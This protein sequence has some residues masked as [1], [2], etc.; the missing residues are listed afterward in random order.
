MQAAQPGAS[1]EWLRKIGLYVSDSN[2]TIDLSQLRIKFRVFQADA[3]HAEPAHAEITVYNL[4]DKTIQS[5]LTEFTTVTLQAGYENGNYSVIFQ[6]QIRQFKHGHE[7]PI[8]S[9]LIIYAA[10]GDPAHMF[11]FVNQ[12]LA[13]GWTAND[14]IRAA[15]DAMGP[16]G[17]TM[18]WNGIANSGLLPQNARGVLMT[19]LGA[20]ILDETGHTN[21]FTWRIEQGQVQICPVNGYGPNDV[22]V[23]NSQSGLIGWPEVTQGGITAT[24]LL[25]PTLKVFNRVQ[26]DNAAIN[27]TTA[28]PS[29]RIPGAPT[30]TSYPGINDLN[31]YVSTAADGIYRI[32]VVEH[33]G[34][35]RGA[36][37]FSHLTLLNLDSSA[38]PDNAVVNAPVNQDFSGGPNG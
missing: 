20:G 24:C 14:K 32:L 7:S 25:N 9:Y 31:Y 36:P 21:G 19:G 8:D 15:V 3:W 28:P 30:V 22:V 12:T 2:Q 38:P 4:K 1:D 23:L 18:G 27:Q 10:D 17:V 13:P 29:L 34:D 16:Y 6:G 11:G 26:I 37:W 5:I 35:T 33:E